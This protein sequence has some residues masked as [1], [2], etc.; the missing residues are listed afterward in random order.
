[1]RSRCD[2]CYEI[3]PGW[4]V[5][6]RRYPYRGR[7]R[8]QQSHSAPNSPRPTSSSEI[9][10]YSDHE[11]IVPSP[12]R[13]FSVK[14]LCELAQFAC[15]MRKITP[16]KMIKTK[17]TS[18]AD[19]PEDASSFPEKEIKEEKSNLSYMKTNN[20]LLT[21]ES[22]NG[23]II[24]NSSD[25]EEL[26]SQLQSFEEANSVKGKRFYDSGISES[27]YSS[28]G[29]IT[30]GFSYKVTPC[31]STNTTTSQVE[32]FD[33]GLD[34]SCGLPK[35]DSKDFQ[36][37]NAFS[38][39]LERVSTVDSILVNPVTSKHNKDS[40]E[41]AINTQLCASQSFTHGKID[42]KGRSS[43]VLAK[44]KTI[45]YPRTSCDPF[46]KKSV[47]R[48]HITPTVKGVDSSSNNLCTI[49]LEQPKDA[50][51]VHGKSGH[52]VC[53]YP[54]GRKLKRNGK[55]CPVCR[56]PIQKVIR[57]FPA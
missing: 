30:D 26:S 43:S 36:E 31:S 10:S 27:F 33:S 19:A 50:S 5:G 4:V 28:Q 49:C 21:S 2:K 51:L 11:I 25:E 6:N 20:P 16:A 7:C 24:L 54:C 46:N 3:R 15:N 42:T 13:T 35:S 56:R 12:D 41:P 39:D 55:S 34:S 8:R 22:E 47:G 37:K 45:N 52:Q 57:N 44:S 18:E 29:S 1:M 48:G 14:S 40:L 53:C 9:A 17:K 38:V 23:T 32:T